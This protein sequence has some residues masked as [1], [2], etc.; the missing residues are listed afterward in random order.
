MLDD[1]IK[2]QLKAYLERLTRPVELVA[3]LDD[4]QGSHELRELLHE[5]EAL[6][7]KITVVEHTDD[8]ERKPSFLITNP[9]IHTGVRFAGVP[10]GNTV[11]LPYDG[12]LGQGIDTIAAIATPTGLGAIGV[13]RVSGPEAIALTDRAFSGRLSEA[14]GHT[15]HF[16]RFRRLDGTV[17]AVRRV[18]LASLESAHAGAGLLVFVEILLEREQRG[19]GRGAQ[20]GQGAGDVLVELPAVHPRQRRDQVALSCSV[21]SFSGSCSL[22]NGGSIIRRPRQQGADGRTQPRYALESGH[23]SGRCAWPRVSL[24]VLSSSEPC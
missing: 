21:A 8:A 1:A 18:P 12:Y 24:P 7:D 6:N 5:I 10:L 2:G 23:R 20:H 16:G 11:F 4:S 22:A 14:A 9:G 15:A 17:N 19:R 13:V 3:S